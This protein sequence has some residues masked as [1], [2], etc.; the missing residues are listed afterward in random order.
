MMFSE[1]GLLI[2]LA[3]MTFQS[4]I[5]LLITYRLWRTK[6]SL[7]VALSNIY[8][9]KKTASTESEAWERFFRD[10]EGGGRCHF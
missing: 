7:L 5:L 8:R 4:L 3:L 10:L 1:T 6:R 9:L 2:S